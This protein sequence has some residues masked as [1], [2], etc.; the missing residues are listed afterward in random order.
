MVLKLYAGNGPAGYRGTFLK[1]SVVPKFDPLLENQIVGHFLKS[2][3]SQMIVYDP[4]D[5]PAS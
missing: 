5:R 4:L 2:L 3:H 1:A